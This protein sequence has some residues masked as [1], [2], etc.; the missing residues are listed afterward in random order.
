LAGDF[1]FAISA[2][3]KTPP[4]I[5]QKLQQ[6]FAEIARSREIIEKFAPLGV[7]MVGSTANEMDAIIQRDSS[8]WAAV[9]RDAGVQVE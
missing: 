7:E 5:L 9:I 6:D 1:W 3:A 2:P 8:R 4:A